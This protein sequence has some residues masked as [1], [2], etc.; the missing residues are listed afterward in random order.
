MDMNVDDEIFKCVLTS[1]VR[2]LPSEF[3]NT[4]YDFVHF[5]IDLNVF[6]E[7]FNRHADKPSSGSDLC[8][9]VLNAKWKS[10]KF[11]VQSYTNWPDGRF[12]FQYEG[13][14]CTLRLQTALD[15]DQPRRWLDTRNNVIRI[16][17]NPIEKL[18]PG[19]DVCSCKIV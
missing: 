6:L 3:D 10:Q 4:V 1:A 2:L 8:L 15:I 7:Y 19:S 17:V 9:S 12:D 16:S 18:T 5:P 11:S 13:N 14:D